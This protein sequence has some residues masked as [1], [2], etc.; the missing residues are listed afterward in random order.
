MNKQI[1]I[2]DNSLNGG[3]LLWYN[4]IIFDSIKRHFINCVC[5]FSECSSFED[6]IAYYFEHY[7]KE[8]YIPQHVQYH[9]Y[10]IADMEQLAQAC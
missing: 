10:T 6:A 8:N 4:V 7:H 5:P 2:I 1:K 9:M 3:C